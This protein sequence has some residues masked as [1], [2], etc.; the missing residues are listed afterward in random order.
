MARGAWLAFD[1][2]GQ[3]DRASDAWR[4][5]RLAALADAGHLGRLLVSSDACKRPALTLFGGKGYA[6]VIDSILPVMRKRGFVD[7]EIDQLL[8]ANP[9][10]MLTG[11]EPSAHPRTAP[12]RKPDTR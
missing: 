9:R 5:D 1:T 4:A 11:T 3:I 10:A 8:V 2:I 12:D 6:H 7:A